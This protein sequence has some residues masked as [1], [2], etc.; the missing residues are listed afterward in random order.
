M[1]IVRLRRERFPDDSRRE[2][3]HADA[4]GEFGVPLRAQRQS[5][6]DARNTRFGRRRDARSIQSILPE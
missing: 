5:V 1:E 4:E 6:S 2:G 3:A